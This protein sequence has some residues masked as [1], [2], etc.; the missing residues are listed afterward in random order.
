MKNFIKK[1][2]L[3]IKLT[4]YSFILKMALLV[5]IVFYTYMLAGTFD[6]ETI[7]PNLGTPFV[8]IAMIF[9]WLA[10]KAIRKDED[11]TLLT[12][13]KFKQLID[14]ISIYD[15][16]RIK[17]NFVCISVSGSPDTDFFI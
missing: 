7:R 4:H 16:K 14:E 6:D 15:I 10:V 11:L 5:V 3:Q 13:E 8:V 2:K 1:G 12:R 9:D 17:D